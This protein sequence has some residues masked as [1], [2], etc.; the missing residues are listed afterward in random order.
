MVSEMPDQAVTDI[1]LPLVADHPVFATCN[2]PQEALA[3]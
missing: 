2:S 3:Q 1:I